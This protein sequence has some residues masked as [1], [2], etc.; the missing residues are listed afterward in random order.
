M[1]AIYDHSLLDTGFTNMLS[2]LHNTPEV[3]CLH[4]CIDRWHE[5][6]NYRAMVQMSMSDTT[7]RKPN[8]GGIHLSSWPAIFNVLFI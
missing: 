1:A 2:L 7:V 4:L 8:T 3:F 6:V 5:K